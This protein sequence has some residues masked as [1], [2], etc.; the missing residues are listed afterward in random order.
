MVV[1]LE[2]L[3]LKLEFMGCDLLI[4]YILHIF[5][6][7]H[8]IWLNCKLLDS[9]IDHFIRICRSI[10]GEFVVVCNYLLFF[11]PLTVNEACKWVLNERVSSAHS[12]KK[13]DTSCWKKSVPPADRNAYMTVT[14]DGGNWCECTMLCIH[15]FCLRMISYIYKLQ[16][17]LIADRIFRMLFIQFICIYIFTC[18]T[19]FLQ[20]YCCCFA[21]SF[22]RSPYRSQWA[23][24]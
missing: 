6:S 11:S 3:Q 15:S 20:S 2:Y 9:L 5:I 12:H 16:I 18:F 4:T 7:Y 1:S 14:D 8:F 22:W 19:S 23:F 17:W 10:A 21:L 24:N 13:I